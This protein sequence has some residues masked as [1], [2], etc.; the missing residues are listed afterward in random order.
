MITKIITKPRKT[1]PK[2]N[3]NITKS[4]NSSNLFELFGGA[5]ST[6]CRGL[7]SGCISGL[8]WLKLAGEIIALVGFASLDQI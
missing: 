1:A 7:A 8:G 6:G 5:M 2:I 4:I 3:P